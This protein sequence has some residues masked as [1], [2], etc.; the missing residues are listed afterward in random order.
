MKFI[1]LYISLILLSCLFL[2]LTGLKSQ[3]NLQSGNTIKS[4]STPEPTYTFSGGFWKQIFEA[5]KDP[6]DY[7]NKSDR[8][9]TFQFITIDNE[10]I[11]AFPDK[12]N[13]KTILS[14][15]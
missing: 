11:Q 10:K 7:L 9:N 8:F 15:I 12:T 2:T 6:E 5:G 1:N 14:K 13:I 4:T 3:V